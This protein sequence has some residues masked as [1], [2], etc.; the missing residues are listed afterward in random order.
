[1]ALFGSKV[2][3]DIKAASARCELAW[4]GVGE[5]PELRIWRIEQFHVKEWP[6]TFK[7]KFYDGDSYIILHTYKKDPAHSDALAFDIHFWIGHESTQDEYGTAAY[8]TV[9][10]D[11][12]MGQAPVQH[13]E[14]MNY[15][16][17]EFSGL[18]EALGGVRLSG[19][20]PDLAQR[21]RDQVMPS[22]GRTPRSPAPC[23]TLHRR[24]G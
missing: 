12:L 16:S 4:K 22:W 17:E 19:L 18:F 10:L 7:G 5:K 21:L 23:R 15:E 11:D 20:D 6:E 2:E 13:R 1:M 8:K 3:K 14:C 24:R 9:E